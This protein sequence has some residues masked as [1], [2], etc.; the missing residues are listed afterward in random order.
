MEQ[1]GAARAA[2]R[3]GDGPFRSPGEAGV[4]ADVESAGHELLLRMAG[5]L[6][7]RLLWRYRDWLAA[8]AVDVLAKAVPK[9]VLRAGIELDRRDYDLAVA[10]L[11]PFGADPHLLTTAL[12][13]DVASD[14][15]TFIEANP[16]ETNRV[17]AVAAVVDAALRG[18]PDVGEVRESW[19][20]GGEPGV[21]RVVLVAAVTGCARLA[22]ELQRVLRVLGDEVPNVEVLP[23]GIELPGYHRAALDRSRRISVGAEKVTHAA[24]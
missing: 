16:D 17:D 21:R 14:T 15:Y 10:A 11:V 20:Y 1:S 9:T 7:D 22:G 19:R 4:P 18:R 8:G 3:G 13:I 23:Q 2:S 5:R 12:G 6:P 24:A